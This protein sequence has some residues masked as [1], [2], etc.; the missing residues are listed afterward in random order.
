METLIRSAGRTPRLRNT[1]YGDAP[2]S[3]RA[4]AFGATELSPIVLNAPRRR[5][6]PAQVA[7]E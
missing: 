7:A 6:R 3:Q 4:K 5:E 1:L 2:E